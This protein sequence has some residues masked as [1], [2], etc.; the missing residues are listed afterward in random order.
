MEFTFLMPCL[1]EAETLAFCIGE[2]QSAVGRLGLDAEVL[3]ADN[4]STDGSAEIAAGCGARV[5]SVSERGYGSALIGGIKAA[6]GKY[7]I[8]GD[9]DG[10]YDFAH[11]DLF[12]Q[13][14]RK[15]AKLVMGDRFKGGIEPGAMPW[16]H[17]WGVPFLSALARW[18]FKTPVRDFH[19]GLRGFDRETALKLDLVCP[20]MEFATEMIARFAQSGE[21][22]VQV[23]TPLRKD[24]RSGK[25]HLR[26]VRDGLR[27]LRFILFCD[28]YLSEKGRNAI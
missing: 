24:R 3:I 28:Q 11:P 9:C 22:I 27:H 1:N 15:G 18:R 5:V 16:S 8:M 4:G 10:S 13:E 7:I 21:K 26:T 17:K 23:P 14:L 6:E 12:V 2:A 25:P 20:G 19:C